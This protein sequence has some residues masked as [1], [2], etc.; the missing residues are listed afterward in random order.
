MFYIYI[1]LIIGFILMRKHLNDLTISA[2]SL[3]PVKEVCPPHKWQMK[4][5]AGESNDR[6][7]CGKCNCLPNEANP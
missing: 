3:T 6:L 2:M 1:G 5:V 7:V 4:R